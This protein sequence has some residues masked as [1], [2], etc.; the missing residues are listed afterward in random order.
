M[1]GTWRL[2]ARA[3]VGVKIAVHAMFMASGDPFKTA[4]FRPESTESSCVDRPPIF[5]GCCSTR[6]WPMYIRVGCSDRSVQ[7]KAANAKQET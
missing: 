3:I 1:F 6:P 5:M 4:V 2:S 7:R